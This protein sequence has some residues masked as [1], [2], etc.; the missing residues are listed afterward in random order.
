MKLPNSLIPSHR[1]LALTLVASC[2]IGVLSAGA[3]NYSVTDLGV[4][5][6]QDHSEANAINSKG[7]VAGTSGTAAFRYTET[8]KEKLENVS[9]F[10]K[11]TSRGFGISDSGLVVGDADF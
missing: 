10:T 8:S 6:D 1:R 5:P 9:K 3:Q 2:A 4:L 7:Q 11:G